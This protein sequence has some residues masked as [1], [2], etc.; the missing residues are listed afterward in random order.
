[1]EGYQAAIGFGSPSSGVGGAVGSKRLDSLGALNYSAYW[2]ADCHWDH[3]NGYWVAHRSS[4]DRKF[5]LQAGYHDNAFVF[6][7]YQGTPASTFTDASLTE[8]ARLDNDGLKFNGDT[9]AS[10]AL[11]D[12]EE[13]TFTPSFTYSSGNGTGSWTYSNAT[14]RYTKI[15]N[16][17]YYSIDIRFYSFSKGSAS[18]Q[19]QL[20]NLPFTPANYANYN[21]VQTSI[22]LYQWPYTTNDGYFP[23]GS[24]QQQGSINRIDLAMNRPDLASTDLNDP[25]SNSMI[26]ASGFYYTT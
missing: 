26:F 20:A 15:G 16:V 7:T 8:L 24:V 11:D 12:Y 19:P 22:T 6:K 4:L 13:G 1:M 21:R 10:N 25:D 9:S 23:G 3:D 5:I 2:A 18:G 14:G 17:C